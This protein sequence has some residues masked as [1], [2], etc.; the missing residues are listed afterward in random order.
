MNDKTRFKIAE[1]EARKIWLEE[2]K[3]LADFDLSEFMATCQTDKFMKNLI[4]TCLKMAKASD[5]C[6][7]D[8]LPGDVWRM[9]AW[10]ATLWLAALN[11]S[12]RESPISEVN[13]IQ[14]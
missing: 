9:A 2:M 13:T 8:E 11:N 4:L 12:N 3:R 5:L 6:R 1:R 10:H 14:V 7:G